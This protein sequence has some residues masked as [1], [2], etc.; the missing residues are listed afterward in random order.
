MSRLGVEARL[1][2]RIEDAVPAPPQRGLNDWR[3]QVT[4]REGAPQTGC[5]IRVGLFMPAHG[6]TSTTVPRVS[7]GD[8][9]GTYQLDDLN[10]HMPGTWEVTLDPTCGEVTDQMLFVFE[11]A[12]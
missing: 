12:R 2:V 8:P 1:Q 10:L 4:D 5:S 3:I 6:H 7:A 9:P 11:I